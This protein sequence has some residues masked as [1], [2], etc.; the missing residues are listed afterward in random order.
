MFTLYL[1]ERIRTRIIDSLEGLTAAQLNH[2][3]AGHNNNLIW[4]LGHLCVTL[5]S[6]VYI[7]HGLAMPISTKLVAQFKPGTTAT[8]PQ[9]EAEIEEIKHTFLHLVTQVKEDMERGLFQNYTPWSTMLKE[10]VDTFEN[11]LSFMHFHE[12]VHLGSIQMQKKSV[13]QELQQA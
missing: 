4:H 10:P 11:C 9:S 1:I 13:L 7:T 2:V 5:S 3:P 6:R 8:A 12:G